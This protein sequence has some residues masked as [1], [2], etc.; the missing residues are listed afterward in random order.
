[1]DVNH[2]NFIYYLNSLLSLQISEDMKQ[3]GVDTTSIRWIDIG[4]KW[5]YKIP[6]VY[7]LVK[8]MMQIEVDTIYLGVN[9]S[10][11]DT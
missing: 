4:V 7:R 2:K 3:I 1:M 10:S 11:K 9:W 8:D 6:Q 5:Y